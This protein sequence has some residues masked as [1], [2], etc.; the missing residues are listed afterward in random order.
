MTQNLPSF[1]LKRN[2]QRVREEILE[3]VHR[4]L[5]SQH[6]ILGPEVAA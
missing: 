3:A 5:D 6:F 2:Y 1:D 4:V